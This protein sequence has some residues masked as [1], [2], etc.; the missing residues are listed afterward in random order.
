MIN[1]VSTTLWKI[2]GG[3]QLAAG[4]LIWFTILRRYVAGIFIIILLFF[5]TYHL[6]E[7]TYD[8]GGS[9]FM[10]VLLGILIWN[11]KFLTGQRNRL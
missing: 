7:N 6:R 1:N 5:T 4:I 10:I 9:I 8:I 2:L 11:P 3:L